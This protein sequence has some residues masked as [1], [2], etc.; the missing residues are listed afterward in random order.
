MHIIILS[1]YWIRWTGSK[2]LCWNF[3]ICSRYLKTVGVHYLAGCLFK[4]NL[5]YLPL[6]FFSKFFS[7]CVSC[8]L[9]VL[10]SPLLIHHVLRVTILRTKVLDPVRRYWNKWPPALLSTCSTQLNLMLGCPC[11]F[12]LS[13]TNKLIYSNFL[14]SPFASATLTSTPPSYGAMLD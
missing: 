6:P 9:S 5:K 8:V 7:S 1:C 4:C 13:F 3:S 14:M 10:T 2:P 11:V 12:F